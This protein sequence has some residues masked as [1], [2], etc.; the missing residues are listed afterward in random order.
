VL[1]AGE[2]M[3]KSHVYALLHH[4]GDHTQAARSL[5]ANGFGE[6]L[7]DVTLPSWVPEITVDTPQE[8]TTP[9]D[10]SFNED[11]RREVRSQLVREY[12][13]DQ[14]KELKLGEIAP[15]NATALSDFLAE[16]DD[17]VR[18]RVTDLWPS[19][20][21]VLLAAA[22]KSGK[23]TMVAANLIPCLVDG[24]QFLGKF[25]VE[26]ITEGTVVLLNMEVGTNTLRRWMRDAD[27]LVMVGL[28][29]AMTPSNR[30]REVWEVLFNNSTDMVKFS[31][32]R[33]LFVAEPWRACPC[34]AL[35]H[36]RVRSRHLRPQSILAHSHNAAE[37]ALVPA[38]ARVPLAPVRIIGR[39]LPRVEWALASRRLDICLADQ[40]APASRIH[41]QHA[42]QRGGLPITSSRAGAR[43][44]P[45]PRPRTAPPARSRGNE[46]P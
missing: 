37:E 45:R 42:P 46:R 4:G 18:Y 1:P 13:R 40:P 28:S 27:C 5:G 11:V 25:D 34:I 29:R 21:R 9:E 17:P 2:G 6:P 32:D 23:T 31:I 20:G 12:A 33:T 14:I 24:G 44:P 38:L 30:T 10:A 22:A 26:Q 41:D 39:G 3:S 8:H 15:L 36:Q 35:R 16:P 7:A 43:L 19:E